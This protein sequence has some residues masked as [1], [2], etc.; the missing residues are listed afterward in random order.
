MKESKSKKSTFQLAFSLLTDGEEQQSLNFVAPDERT[1]D[2]WVDGLNSLLGNRMSSKEVDAD[3]ELLLAMEIKLKLLET[4]G[5]EIPDVP[6]EIPPPCPN[7][8]FNALS[9]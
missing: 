6:P 8:D 3:L 1:F 4:E 9:T 7:Y 5:Y 2:F